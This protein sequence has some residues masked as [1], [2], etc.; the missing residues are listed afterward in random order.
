MQSILKDFFPSEGNNVAIVFVH[1]F[2]GDVE[3]TWGNIPEFL[4]QQP[5]LA[6]WDLV[7]FG[8]E[9]KRRFDIVNLWSAD[10]SLEEI[11]TKLDTALDGRP[12]YEKIALVAHSMGGL[13]VQRALVK[14]SK[15]RARVSP[16]HPVRD[17]QPRAGQGHAGFVAQ[18]ADPEHERERSVRRKPS[19]GMDQARCGEEAAAAPR[20]AG[21]S[22]QFVPPQLLARSLSPK[23]CA[24]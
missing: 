18:A 7:G 14:Y 9:S 5:E 20:V 6:G 21:E 11:S 22:D 13:I 16:S 12:R 15:L 2:T 24:A 19:R 1:G 23:P 8:Y 10:A 4:N 17:A 3:K